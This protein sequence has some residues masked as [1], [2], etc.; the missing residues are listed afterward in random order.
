MLSVKLNT[1]AE[2]LRSELADVVRLFLGDVPFLQSAGE[3]IITHTHREEGGL[4]TERA[5]NGE[6]AYVHSIS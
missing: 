1:N 5:A 4:W 2:F 3:L 6:K